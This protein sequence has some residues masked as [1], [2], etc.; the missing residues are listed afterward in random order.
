[1]R[2]TEKSPKTLSSGQKNPKKPKN[3]PKKKKKNKNKKKTKKPT[4]LFFFF[5]PGFFPT[6]LFMI[7]FAGTKFT[8]FFKTVLG[9]LIR[10]IR[11]FL[12]LRLRILFFSHKCLERTEIMLD[13][14]EF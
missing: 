12:G 8:S 1:M 11:M 5:K 2:E 10:R 9:F 3:P 14:I 7:L 4:R 13:K 6:L